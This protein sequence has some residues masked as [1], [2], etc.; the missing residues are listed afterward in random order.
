MVTIAPNASAQT[1]PAVTERG[2]VAA[3]EKPTDQ[4]A[5]PVLVNYQEGLISLIKTQDQ[6]ALRNN[7]VALM[8]LVQT[9]DVPNMVPGD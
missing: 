9:F 5:V 7:A 3:R 2:V 8:K 6:P 4:N 1:S